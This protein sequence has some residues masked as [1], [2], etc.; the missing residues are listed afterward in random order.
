MY[1]LCLHHQAK[2]ELQVLAADEVSLIDK[3]LYML[4][5][6][7]WKNGTRVKKLRAI[8]KQVNIFEA[9]IDK[10]NRMLFTLFYDSEL[11]ETVILVF[12]LSIHHD[13]VIRTAQSVLD[14]EIDYE[15]YEKEEIT[16]GE[17]FIEFA[18]QQG[19][20]W[21]ADHFFYQFQ[22]LKAYEIDEETLTRFMM[23]QDENAD[24]FWEMKLRL[25]SE[26]RALLSKPLP[27]LISGTAGSGKTTILIHKMLEEPAVKK[28]YITYTKQLRDDAEKQFLSLV[29]GLDEEE[30][31]RR[32]TSFLTFKDFMENY[33]S[34]RFQTIVMKDHFIRYYDNISKGQH[35]E[36]R[37]PAL[38]LWEEIR[39]VIKGG[40]FHS[41]HDYLPKEKYLALSV[42]EAPNFSKSREQVYN[43]FLSYQDYLC[44]QYLI[45]E[46]DLLQQILKG[47]LPSYDMVL[48]DEIQDLTMLHVKLLF[49]LAKNDARRIV[50]SGDDHQILHHSGFRWENVKNAFYQEF[51]ERISE[52]YSLSKNFRNTG[53]IA[54]LAREINM[55]QKNYTDFKYKSDQTTP[56][57]FGEVPKLLT[58]IE[59]HELYPMMNH[60]G[61]YD[62]I[63]VRTEDIKEKILKNFEKQLQNVPLVFTIY[64]AK[65]LEFRKVILWKMIHEEM[66]EFAQWKKIIGIVKRKDLFEISGNYVMQRFIRYEA[67]L[68]YVAVTRGMKEC[69]IYDGYKASDLWSMES[70]QKQLEVQTTV[71]QV[72]NKVVEE[73]STKDWKEQGDLFFRRGLY[74]QAQSCYLRVPTDKNIERTLLLCQAY[75]S[76]EQGDFEKGG[77]LFEQAELY[78]EAIECY[79]VSKK[80]NSIISICKRMENGEYRLK[81]GS[82]KNKYKIK[83]FDDKKQW[84]GSGIYCSRQG[85]YKEALLRFERDESDC[86]SYIDD[87]YYTAIN[88]S[89]I[90]VEELRN[91]VDFFAIS[92]KYKDEQKVIHIQ[93]TLKFMRDVVYVKEIM[94]LIK[95]DYNEF[96]IRIILETFKVKTPL[97]QLAPI[98]LK[99]DPHVQYVFALI[100]EDKGMS[101]EVI[102][103]ML[104]RAVDQ[105]H[106]EAQFMLGAIY[107]DEDDIE[108]AIYYYKLSA[109][110]KHPVAAFYL[111]SHFMHI[112]NVGEGMHWMNIAL[113]SKYEDAYS[114]LAIFLREGKRIPQDIQ[115][116][117]KLVKEYEKLVR[118]RQQKE[119]VLQARLENRKKEIDQ[120]YC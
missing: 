22:Q 28:L 68:L 42:N 27:L 24:E 89:S 102:K 4:K 8:N 111:G 114:D 50:F 45:D 36:K 113:K 18:E 62:A 108:N 107:E 69:L 110:K 119:K 81:W 9:R 104:K 84:I 2:E 51:N 30:E 100:A 52:V 20:L 19:D 79:E 95:P 37:Y 86:S 38:M 101:E 76:K 103:L 65:G 26:Q 32:K 72:D 90:A 116:A 99:E 43:I 70:I 75:L 59:E 112:K 61:P 48:C 60:F 71:Q 41:G 77:W 96:G 46:Q 40:V 67:S 98:F 5:R 39:G 87:I 16:T 34:E 14:D 83:E 31:Y 78:D 63:L 25:T 21:K 82:L 64:E 97:K 6:G 11:D 80:Y 23:K 3:R 120:I 33:M 91:M 109:G 7:H 106:S 17:S 88:D 47:F 115:R 118:N 54:L 56:F 105:N 29:T 1:S 74:E 44:S 10:G 73:F 85:Y 58:E 57:H 35:L 117:K 49:K 15:L 12:R 13:D 66:S 55:L 92:V 94:Q 93:E 53:K